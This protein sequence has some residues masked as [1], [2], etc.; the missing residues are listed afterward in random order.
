[1]GKIPCEVCGSHQHQFLFEGW[2][3]VFGIP[4]RFKIVQCKECGLIFVNPQPDP[5][6][7]KQYYPKDYYI[8]NPSHYREYSWLRRKVLETYWGYQSPSKTREDLRLLKKM[9]LL[10]FR[11][12]YRHAIPFVEGGRLL[13]I[14]CGNGTE[15]Y[16]LKL[17]GWEAYGVEMDLE[18]S[19]RARSKGI[20]VCTGDLFKANYPA[21]FFDVVRMSF[22][23]EH[24]P[25]PR[26]ALFE[27]SR[28]LMPKGRIHISIQ[29]ARSLNYW[30]F[31]KWWFSLDVP[32][33]LFSFTP[34]TIEKLLFPLG[35]RVQALW[36]ESGERSFLAS[37]QYLVNERYGRGAACQGAQP[38]AE[39]RFL[40]LLF[41]P[42]CW[43]VDRLG[44]GDLMHLEIVKR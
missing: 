10:P 40:K 14:G 9:I 20:S 37:I 36:F 41:R 22:V 15:L 32:R 4:G 3:R 5:E 30:L 42:F 7:L 17:M 43:A 39:S 29:N 34:K 24:L 31:R 18:A 33:H 35:L 12:K 25:N 23:L 26:E 16:K 1:M 8:S 21:H 13:D 28:I 6:K 11:V 19:E 44:F 27:I 2:D 38:I